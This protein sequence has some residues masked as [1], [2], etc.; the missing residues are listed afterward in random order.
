[1]CERCDGADWGGVFLFFLKTSLMAIFFDFKARQLNVEEDGGGMAILL[2]F[3]MQ[4]SLYAQQSQIAVVS[5]AQSLVQSVLL[6]EPPGDD[7]GSGTCTFYMSPYQFFY[8]RV[9]A[10]RSPA[11]G[12]R[13]SAPC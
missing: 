6:L 4:L 3:A 10:R 7:D 2:F 1:V 13:C 9:R 5:W 12:M 11:P 8:F